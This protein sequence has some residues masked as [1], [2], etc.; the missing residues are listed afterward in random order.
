M[1]LAEDGDRVLERLDRLHHVLLLRVEL[2][3]LLLAD[4]RR[5]TRLF[6]AGFTLTRA[7]AVPF[8]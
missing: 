1:V 5:L 2:L 3:Q 7:A 4:R 8:C 6:P